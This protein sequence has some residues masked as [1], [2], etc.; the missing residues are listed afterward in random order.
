MFRRNEQPRGVGMIAT[1]VGLR[2]A[3]T[4]SGLSADRIHELLE[5]ARLAPSSH[6]TQPWR[7]RAEPGYVDVFVE[8]GRWLPV[9]DDDRREL[10]L[11]LG[12]AIENFLVAAEHR[13]LAHEVT[14][15]PRPE[16]ERLVARIRLGTEG[17]PSPFRDP[18]LFEAIGRRRTHRG[19]YAAGPIADDVLAKLRACIVDDGITL[20]TT[21]DR[22]VLGAVADLVDRGDRLEYADPAFRRELA[23]WVGRGVFGTRRVFR[24][25]AR[26][27]I[28]RVDTGAAMAKED[29]RRIENSGAL[30][31]VISITDDARSRLR[32]GQALERVWL[33]ATQLGLA[34]QPMSQPLQIPQLRR[35]LGVVVGAGHACP[36]HLF[37]LGYPVSEAEHRAPRFGDADV[38]LS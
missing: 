3:A 7:F 16:D 31:T 4:A 11:S 5:W 26:F 9:A 36:Q 2:G 35:A 25:I 29:R 37:R 28:A 24:P 17:R 22:T 10:Y 8:L 12:C 20:R 23:A 32:A 34:V 18:G 30:A 14:F 27:A 19:E 21:T 33:R 6:N 1:G 13:G 38:I 15:F